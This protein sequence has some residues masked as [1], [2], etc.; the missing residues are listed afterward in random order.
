MELW[1]YGRRAAVREYLI[2]R[3]F[4]VPQRGAF[5]GIQEFFSQVLFTTLSTKR[6]TA[7]A[8]DPMATDLEL[9]NPPQRLT[10]SD[11]PINTNPERPTHSD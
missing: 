11:Q 4:L 8:T 6:P 7:A 5:P 3:D 1:W 2:E 9:S 10:Y